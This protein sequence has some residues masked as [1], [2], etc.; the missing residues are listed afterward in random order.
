MYLWFFLQLAQL[1]AK[2][3]AHQHTG[4]NMNFSRAMCTT[5]TWP[6]VC[7]DMLWEC[8]DDDELAYLDM[9]YILVQVSDSIKLALG[10]ELVWVHSFGYDDVPSSFLNALNPPSDRKEC[11]RWRRQRSDEEENYAPTYG[12][13]C[14]TY[15][16]EFCN[17][18][19]WTWVAKYCLSDRNSPLCMV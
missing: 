10:A 4:S 11:G 15:S 14:C 1:T 12:M 19:L 7:H 17:F 8:V 18:S 5:T 9:P 2:I 3:W 13:S 6:L 16:K